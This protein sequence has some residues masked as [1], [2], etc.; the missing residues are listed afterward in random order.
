MMAQECE[1]G[2]ARSF[3]SSSGEILP[4]TAVIGFGVRL[5][6]GD[7]LI[8][9]VG[10]NTGDVCRVPSSLPELFVCQSVSLGESL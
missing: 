3:V 2:K 10:A 7:I 4:R 6:Q 1:D 5:E 9:I 8:T